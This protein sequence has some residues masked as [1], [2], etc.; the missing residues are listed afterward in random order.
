MND[1]KTVYSHFTAVLW[2]DKTK[3]FS[4]RRRA[5]ARVSEQTA[6]KNEWKL[7][8]W[9]LLDSDILNGMTLQPLAYRE[10]CA[11]FLSIH[12]YIYIK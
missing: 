12:V 2:Q 9:N 1:M 3:L 6:D 5:C 7:N 10:K 8:D 11:L 4:R